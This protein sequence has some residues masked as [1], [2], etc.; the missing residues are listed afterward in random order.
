MLLVDQLFDRFWRIRLRE[1][2]TDSLAGQKVSEQ[3]VG[4]AVELRSGD[5]VAPQLGYILHGVGNR[6]LTA[7]DAQRIEAALERGDAP[8]EHRGGRVADA[9]VAIALCLQ[10]EQRRGMLG[11]VK[12]NRQTVW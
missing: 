12:G 8:L 9:G 3:R 7:G 2:D 10:I 1:S 5:D 4:G 6:R 11:A